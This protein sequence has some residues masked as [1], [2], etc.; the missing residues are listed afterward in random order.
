MSEKQLDFL[1]IFDE[2]TEKNNEASE[3]DLEHDSEDEDFDLE[4]NDPLVFE[5]AEKRRRLEAEEIMKQ[6]AVAQKQLELEN[7]RFKILNNQADLHLSDFAPFMG[8]IESYQKRLS[9]FRRAYEASEN[10]P[11]KEALYRKLV[12]PQL[13][14]EENFRESALLYMRYDKLKK[15]QSVRADNLTVNWQRKDRAEKKQNVGKSYIKKRN[16]FWQTPNKRAGKD[17]ATG[18]YL[19]LDKDSD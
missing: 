13:E 6:Q 3:P 4:E 9:D 7:L 17:A 1:H 12:S 11:N 19:E 5:E 14:D 16:T 10:G 15:E 18:E 2:E 8:E